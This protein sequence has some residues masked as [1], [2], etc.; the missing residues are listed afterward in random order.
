MGIGATDADH[1]CSIADAYADRRLVMVPSLSCVPFEI[2]NW[3]GDPAIDG[4][5]LSASGLSG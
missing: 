3:I 2:R 1:A 5:F 4:R